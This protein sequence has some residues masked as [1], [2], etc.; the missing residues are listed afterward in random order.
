MVNLCIRQPKFYVKVD[1]TIE[2]LEIITFLH[3]LFF[4]FIK[5]SR[6]V[7]GIGR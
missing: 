1:I 7:N 2:I 5:I 4:L 6:L 3:C